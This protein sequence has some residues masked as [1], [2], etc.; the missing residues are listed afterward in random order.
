MSE[1]Q[2]ERAIENLYE[3]ASARDELTDE[4][5]QTLLSWGEEQIM[6]LAE[7][8]LDDAVFEAAMVH[9]STLLRQMNRL[10]AR[11]DNLAPEEQAQALQGIAEHAQGIGLA[12]TQEQMGFRAQVIPAS[13]HDNVRELIAM[14]GGQQQDNRTMGADDPPEEQKSL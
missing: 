13:I 7:Q 11:R 14:V 12:K 10:A 2:A 5:A 1:A 6:R 8:G 3:N 4:E 9:L